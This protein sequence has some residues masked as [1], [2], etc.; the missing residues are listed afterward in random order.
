MREEMGGTCDSHSQGES[1]RGKERTDSEESERAGCGEESENFRQPTGLGRGC[2]PMLQESKL[3]LLRRFLWMSQP[4]KRTR[5]APPILLLLLQRSRNQLRVERMLLRRRGSEDRLLRSDQ[6]VDADGDASMDG[7]DA[8]EP[9]LSSS[10]ELT[11]LLSDLPDGSVADAPGQH[12][13]RRTRAMKTPVTTLL[14]EGAAAK[15]ALTSSASSP[16][17]LR[18]PAGSHTALQSQSAHVAQHRSARA[19]RSSEQ[20]GDG[21]AD[22]AE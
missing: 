8:N 16:S 14:T 19:T 7:T 18:P 15:L 20:A 22:I 5:Q 6:R 17:G 12:H 1:G 11:A 13:Q 2:T 9:P 21:Q 10:K 3:R 4:N